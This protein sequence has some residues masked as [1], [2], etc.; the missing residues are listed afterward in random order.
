MPPLGPLILLLSPVITPLADLVLTPFL[1]PRTLARFLWT[2][3]LPIVPLATRCDGVVSL[4]RVCSPA[5][6]QALTARIPSAGHAWE[7]GQA[8]TGTPL[9]AFTYLLGYPV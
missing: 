4:V 5:E 8:S 9:L 3:L 1:K 6:L 7:I 2:Y